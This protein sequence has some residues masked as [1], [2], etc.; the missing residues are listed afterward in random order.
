MDMTVD[1]VVLQVTVHDGGRVSVWAREG[2]TAE[3]FA[4]KL[5]EIAEQFESGQITR[6][7]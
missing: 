3:E 2:L 5:R 7:S 1:D 4:A 6:I